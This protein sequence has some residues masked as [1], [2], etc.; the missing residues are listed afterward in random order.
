MASETSQAGVSLW[1]RISESLLED[2]R[3][4]VLK[5][6]EQLPADVA[7]AQ[8]FGVN[9]HT[10]R[11]AVGH[12]QSEGILRVEHGRGTFVVSDVLEY[13]LGE[14]PRFTANLLQNHRAPN[15]SVVELKDLPAPA[16][17]AQSLDMESGDA[18]V[19]LTV[20]GQADGVPISLGHNYFPAAR[21]P[22]L[23][24]A[25]RQQSVDRPQE[26]SITQALRSVGI[27]TYRRRQTRLAARLPT[28]EEA[29]LLRMARTQ[30]IIETES[31]D[32][33]GERNVPV[34][35][36]RTCFRADRL[37]FVVSD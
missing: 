28:L 29:R 21:L 16:A 12:L 26:I 37:Q 25:F 22:K 11:R 35:Y 32:V 27:D 7:I 23:H 30:P 17:V 13:R 36:A 31:V 10:V 3:T 9:R 34:T 8:R 33:G 2:I 4:G 18:C 5:N 15:R 1:R 6:G 20:L 14:T 24:E 19:L